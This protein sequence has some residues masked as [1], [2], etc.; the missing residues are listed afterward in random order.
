MGGGVAAGFSAGALGLFQLNVVFVYFCRNMW[1]T[2]KITAM[3]MNVS[4]VLNI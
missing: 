3:E 2:Y 1:A 4:A